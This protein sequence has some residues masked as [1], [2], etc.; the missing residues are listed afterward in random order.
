MVWWLVLY[1]GFF[2]H[3]NMI[4]LTVYRMHSLVCGLTEF[5]I[6]P[7][8]SKS[9]DQYSFEMFKTPLRGILAEK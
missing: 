6:D 5:T 3:P 4:I 2:F 8:A 1:N 9:I 7:L